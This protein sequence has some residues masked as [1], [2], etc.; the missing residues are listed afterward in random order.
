MP[1]TPERRWVFVLGMHRSGTSAVA[2]LL[3]ALGCALPREDDRLDWP[4]SN[5]EHFESLAATVHNDRL[6][7]SLR[8]AWD[9][10]PALG[11][12][13]VHSAAVAAAGRSAAV[14]AGAFSQGGVSLW[15]DP[16]LCLLLP[17][18]RAVLGDPAGAVLVWRAP[19]AVAASSRRRDRMPEAEGLALWERYNRA[20]LESLA[21]LPVLVADYDD[22]VSKP[23][24]FAGSCRRWLDSLGAGAISDG[25]V[26]RRPPGPS[27]TEREAVE[28]PVDPALRHERQ[29]PGAQASLSPAQAALQDEL[30]QLTGPH[31]HL[32]R[33]DLPDETP[34]TDVRIEVRRT[35]AAVR[36]RLERERDS[37]LLELKRSRLALEGAQETIHR[38]RD[39][40]S[41]RVTRPLRWSTSRLEQLRA[42]PSRGS[43]SGGASSHG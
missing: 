18:W 34:A 41:W 2:G 21:G 10:P 25:E 23:E 42:G 6:L 22:V 4:E 37:A 36:R 13:W 15:K 9:A 12:H 32:G 33:V 24:D 11:G 30:R 40:T 39:S 16:R 28:L 17:Y 14:L 20:A 29:S 26:A 5:P 35:L 8:G 38:L 43:A 27:V 3:G 7:E 1:A 19:L 31:D